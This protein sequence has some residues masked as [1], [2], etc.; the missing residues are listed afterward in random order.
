MS[1]LCFFCL[2]SCSKGIVTGGSSNGGGGGG[3][4]DNVLSSFSSTP[5]MNSMASDFMDSSTYDETLNNARELE[6]NFYV[7]GATTPMKT[8]SMN[9]LATAVTDVGLSPTSNHEAF[10]VVNWKIFLCGTNAPV[11]LASCSNVAVGDEICV[12]NQA[13]NSNGVVGPESAP[14]CFTYVD[15]LIAEL[16][17]AYNPDI[18][19]DPSMFDVFSEIFLSDYQ[20]HLP[21]GAPNEVTYTIKNCDTG[22]TLSTA[23]FNNGDPTS[24]S[25]ALSAVN[26]VSVSGEAGNPISGNNG[27]DGGTYGAWCYSKMGWIQGVSN[28]NDYIGVNK[29]SDH[30]IEMYATD[31]S[32]FSNIARA[33]IDKLFLIS[34]SQLNLEY[35]SSGLTAL[36]ALFP[37]DPVNSVYRGF[38]CV[39]A[40]Q[41]SFDDSG[42][43]TNL[44]SWT[45]GCP[46]NVVE[47]S[48]IVP[49]A[50]ANTLHT[51]TATRNTDARFPLETVLMGE[52][53]VVSAGG[54]SVAKVETSVLLN[55]NS[56]PNIVNNSRDVQFVFQT[57]IHNNL[58]GAITSNADIIVNEARIATTPGGL[59]S[60]GT[61]IPLSFMV[62]SGAS[63]VTQTPHTETFSEDGVYDVEVEI[64]NGTVSALENFQLIQVSY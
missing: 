6:W 62:D 38:N 18:L 50:L 55:A 47:T 24:N 9:P 1:F 13:T 51:L 11:L 63:I 15:A 59:P 44:T 30:C 33:K 37:F 20:T 26:W 14:T 61:I 27:I 31:G 5:D 7:A 46:L 58:G 42:A 3:N 8:F 2:F 40:S 45:G 21:A 57:S 64:G 39:D 43:V 53:T 36:E 49:S 54:N 25:A 29:G 48:S 22:A 17:T 52:N 32:S 16:T 19:A 4:S 56:T 34:S 41:A 28:S 12:T 35:D 60:A 10:D 23:T